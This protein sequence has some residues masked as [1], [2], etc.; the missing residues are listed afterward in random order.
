MTPSRRGLAAASGGRQPS[1]RHF[2]GS[3]V[4]WV[5]INDDLPQYPEW[6]PK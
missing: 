6:P 3:K 5:R 2:V 4:P 1:T